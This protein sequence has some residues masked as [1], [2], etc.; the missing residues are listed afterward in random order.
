MFSQQLVNGIT[1]GSI[2]VL[3][4]LGYSM[5]YGILQIIN[6]AHADVL[7]IGTF[8][9]LMF[10]SGLNV[11][12][13]PTVILA[14]FCTALVGMSVERIAYRP[15]KSENRRMAVLVSALGMSIFLQNLARVI[16]GSR[17]H[18]FPTGIPI[19]LFEI[20]TVVI[21]NIQ[22]IIMI[23]TLLVLAVLYYIVY[24][25]KM[26]TAMR[27][28]SVSIDHAK[29][30]GINANSIVALTF[31][32]GTFMAAIAGICVGTYYDAV[33]PTMGYILGMKAFAAAILGGIGSIP[34][35]VAGG[36]IIGIIETLGASYISSGYRDAYA[37]IIM[38]VVLIVY[39]S[40]LFG[41]KQ[42]DKV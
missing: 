37:F 17:T 40:G 5:V 35:A 41:A 25:T 38:V 1:I 39:P 36:F 8:I 20:G 4:A 23:V 10:C 14:A 7:M 3:I 26:G 28:C 2:Y 22:V 33:Y 9:G 29:L 21:T 6:F 18:A 11:P 42:L 30:M 16:W 13:L 24:K 32:I 15:V 19:K 12:I 27:A 31:G 34:G